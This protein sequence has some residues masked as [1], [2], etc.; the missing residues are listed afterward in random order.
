MTNENERCGQCTFWYALDNKSVIVGTPRQGI[1]RA[2]PP[3]PVVV[4]V[5]QAVKGT[6]LNIETLFPQT[7]DTTPCCG[8]YEQRA[9]LPIAN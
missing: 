5:K 6:A 3:I 4:G 2:R 8:L 1:C 7:L 9:A